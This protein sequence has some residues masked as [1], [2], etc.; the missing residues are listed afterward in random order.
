MDLI[1]GLA[2]DSVE[3]F[4]NTLDGVVALHPESITVHT[5]ALKRS[6]N[7]NKNG[8]VHFINDGEGAGQMLDYVDTVLTKQDYIPYYLYRQSRMVGNLENTGWAKPGYENYYNVYIMDESHTILACGAGAVS[9]IKHP[10]KDE[11]QRIFNFKFPYEYIDRYQ[12]M[13]DRKEKVKSIYKQFL[14]SATPSTN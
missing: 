3:S 6:S 8:K 7:I 9:K 10:Y 2:G 11:L 5:L 14:L 12:E 1:V 4:R 13:L